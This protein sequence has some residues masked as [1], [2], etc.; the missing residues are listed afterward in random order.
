MKSALAW[1]GVPQSFIHDK[2]SERE[3]YVYASHE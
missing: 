3:V 2:E 1:S